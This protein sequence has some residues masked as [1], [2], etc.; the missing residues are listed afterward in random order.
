MSVH[1]KSCGQE[2]ITRSIVSDMVPQIEASLFA[3]IPDYS[4]TIR[5]PDGVLMI[6][7]RLDSKRDRKG[8]RRSRA[9]ILCLA[10]GRP[11]LALDDSSD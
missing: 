10:L 7:H 6:V 1:L 11:P 3:G 8:K 9:V 4:I 2:E 5:M